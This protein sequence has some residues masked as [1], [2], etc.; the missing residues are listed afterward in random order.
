MHQRDTPTPPIRIESMT[1]EH[2]AEAYALWE[3]AEGVGVSES[4]EYEPIGR[5]LERNPGL[6]C[7]ALEGERVV[8][9]VL[10]GHD[11]RRGAIWH[12]VVRES[13]RRRGIGRRLMTTCQETLRRAGI[14]RS[15]LFI[16]DGNDT[17][18][19][20]WESL[21]WQARPELV[22]MSCDHTADRDPC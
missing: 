6:S 8:G 12:L 19:R 17:G 5:Y 15:Y 20:F 2:H 16:V 7:V 22:P 14:P 9:V 11:G 3:R 10:A 4:D 18:R 13:H 21:G 1:L